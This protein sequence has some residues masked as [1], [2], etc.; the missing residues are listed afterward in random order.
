MLCIF[1]LRKGRLPDTLH[2]TGGFAP[3]GK[4]FDCV[5][6]IFASLQDSPDTNPRPTPV[7]DICERGMGDPHA[8]LFEHFDP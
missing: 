1:D 6:L 3:Q 5:V 4:G 8:R 2:G 7:H